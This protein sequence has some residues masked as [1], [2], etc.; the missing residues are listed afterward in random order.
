MGFLRSRREPDEHDESRSRI[1]QGGIPLAAERRLQALGAEGS[2]FTS[3]LSVNEFSL[4]HRLGP[5]PLAQ[6]MG[7]SVVRPA[8][9]LLPALPP[10]QT[11]AVF[12]GSWYSQNAPS[13]SAALNL[14]TDA[15]PAQ[16]RNYLWHMDVVCELDVLTGAWNTARLKALGR[17][18]EEALQVG[19]DSVAGVHLHRGDHDFGR[20][21]IE[22]VVTGTAI[23]H[24]NSARDRYPVLTDISVQDLWRLHESGY[25]AVGLLAASIVVFASPPRFTRLRRLR[26]TRRYQDLAELSRAFHLARE[27]LRIRL[28]GQ[29]RDAKADGAVGVEFAHSVHREELSLASSLGTYSQRGWHLGR[30]GVPYYVTGKGEAERKGWMIT[31]HVSGTAV[32]RTSAG[33]GENAKLAVR[34]GAR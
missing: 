32:R 11:S 2:M 15:S 26:T 14:I 29:V 23:R 10:S 30:F 27:A 18:T 25:A 4:L 33:S 20:R 34:M 8:V 17:L 19:A 12:W 9:Q 16:I 1:E 24:P 22:Y 31:M 6:V 5:R 3:G 7:A 28:E 13:P 21:M